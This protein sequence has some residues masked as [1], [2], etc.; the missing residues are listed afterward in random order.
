MG[1]KC[2]QHLAQ[3]EKK[4][5][6]YR[7]KKISTQRKQRQITQQGINQ[8]T[9]TD[10][11]ITW[12][13]QL[14]QAMSGQTTRKNELIN[15]TCTMKGP[16]HPQNGELTFSFSHHGGNGLSPSRLPLTSGSVRRPSF[17]CR[18]G[19]IL[20]KVVLQDVLRSV[21]LHGEWHRRLRPRTAWSQNVAQSKR[22]RA[23]SSCC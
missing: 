20:M 15:S 3:D 8:Q 22:L 1:W 14:Y 4:G 7:Q 19:T 12:A 11:I 9:R 10:Q 2:A 18:A 17:Y 13:K 5:T 23:S 16:L 21:R 6:K